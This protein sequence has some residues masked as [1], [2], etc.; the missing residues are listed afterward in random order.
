M[1]LSWTFEFTADG[2]H[3][4]NADDTPPVEVAVWKVPSLWV[5]LAI[6]AV[7]GLAA[8]SAWRGVVQG[9]GGQAPVIAVLPFENVGGDEDDRLLATGLHINVIGELGANPGLVLVS[10]YAVLDALARSQDRGRIGAALGAQ[11][12]IE[13]SLLRIDKRIGLQMRMTAVED[14]RQVWKE[15]YERGLGD[16][17]AVQRDL[18]QAV[19]DALRVGVIDSPTLP[20][21]AELDPR[22]VEAYLRGV[23]QRARFDLETVGLGIEEDRLK[24]S[25]QAIEAFEH[26]LEIAPEFAQAW[27]GLAAA[28]ADLA[29]ANILAH[30]FL[31]DYPAQAAA[32]REALKRADALDPNLFDAALVRA[33]IARLDY[34]LEGGLAAARRAYALRPSDDSA[35]RYLTRALWDAGLRYESVATAR[36]WT[37][38]EPSDP[39]AWS[40][41]ASRQ[42]AS[43]DFGAAARSYDRAIALSSPPSLEL[44]DSRA[45][46]DFAET[47]DIRGYRRSLESLVV[48]FGE[49]SVF[50]GLLGA[51]LPWV[52][53]GEA[54][55]LPELRSIDYGLP[56]ENLVQKGTCPDVLG[57]SL[58]E[59][60]RMDAAVALW[61]ECV[62][63]QLAQDPDRIPARY[64]AD[65]YGV[66]GV[67]QARIG[68]FDVARRN[69]GH[70]ETLIRSDDF[71]DEAAH[72]R[73][74]QGFFRAEI[75][76]L[77]RAVALIDQGLSMR[78]AY[79]NL[80]PSPWVV[81]RYDFYHHPPG[82]PNKLKAYEPFRQMM[83]RHGVDTEK[84]VDY[85]R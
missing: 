22:A 62:A 7:F 50:W 71:S 37:V 39:Q 40:H 65:H 33:H 20:K 83:R 68:E 72:S 69:L 59:K 56:V 45:M 23:A 10:R 9:V 74:F 81:W 38:R 6:G 31:A 79:L 80:V 73:I 24:R 1:I 78:G 35:T 47:G 17:F 15:S 46:V 75:G 42:L 82:Q 60:G 43:R 14:G 34:D 4:S 49:R 77:D 32:A 67:H 53:F 19:S 21:V 3:R 84:S 2:V 76:D 58:V 13:G 55:A 12:V 18:A 64:K 57:A 70:A 66:L 5:A 48:R 26:A 11:Y 52:A 61:R 8:V 25:A 36:L 30:R 28:H 27:A 29:A 51:P 16:V 85:H 54:H 44:L 41:L 63:I